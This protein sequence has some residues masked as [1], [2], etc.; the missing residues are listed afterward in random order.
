VA[1][2]TIKQGETVVLDARKTKLRMAAITGLAV[3][4][5]G[6]SGHHAVHADQPYVAATRPVT[7]APPPAPLLDYI[8][9]S[10]PQPPASV[11]SSVRD[12]LIAAGVDKD[13]IGYVADKVSSAIAADIA[14]HTDELRRYGQIAIASL[15]PL[16]I[17]ALVA[18]FRH[19]Q[20]PVDMRQVESIVR[21]ARW[22]REDLDVRR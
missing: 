17:I 9:Y 12:A 10:V 2:K 19:Q 3:I 8:P 20:P 16:W 13:K 22:A 14:K 1:G 15:V 18:L 6:I 4:I 11:Y 21:E 7:T 5:Y